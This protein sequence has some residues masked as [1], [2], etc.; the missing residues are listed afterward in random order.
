MEASF[1]EHNEKITSPYTFY[2]VHSL[3]LEE[4]AGKYVLPPL[5]SP[6]RTSFKEGLNGK[7]VKSESTFLSVLRNIQVMPIH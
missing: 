1:E 5:S 6:P 7:A 4:K 2:P 3:P